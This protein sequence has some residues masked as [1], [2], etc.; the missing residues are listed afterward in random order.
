M[1]ELGRAWP[2]DGALA[3][4]GGEIMALVPDPPTP[5]TRSP[6]NG[7]AAGAIGAMAV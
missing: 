3:V 4:V 6:V 7:I 2:V 5:P 1:C